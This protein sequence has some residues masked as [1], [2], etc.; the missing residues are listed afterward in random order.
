VSRPKA[1]PSPHPFVADPD[2]LP[3]PADLEKRA[4]C[5][6][7]HMLGQSGDAHHTLPAAPDVDAQQRAAGDTGEDQ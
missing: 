7:C 5:F 2:L 4:V 3:H 6:T 1:K